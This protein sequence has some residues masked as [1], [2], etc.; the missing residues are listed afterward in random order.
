VSDQAARHRLAGLRLH[1]ERGVDDCMDSGRYRPAE[2]P[3]A[4]CGRGDVAIT[5]LHP[6]K[7]DAKPPALRWG[8]RFGELCSARFPR[9]A[10]G[11]SVG[12][13]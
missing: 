12:A 1:R 11:P 7:A 10:A 3:M 13:P 4:A 5:C 8:Q 9:A 6:A 2:P